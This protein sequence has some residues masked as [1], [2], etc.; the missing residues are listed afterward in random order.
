M[1]GMRQ[2]TP[3]LIRGRHKHRVLIDL[4]IRIALGGQAVE[5]DEMPGVDWR[6]HAARQDGRDVDSQRRA[7]HLGIS[8]S[9]ST[10][11]LMRM[12]GNRRRVRVLAGCGMRD[13]LGIA[14]HSLTKMTCPLCELRA[15]TA[16]SRRKSIEVR[17]AH[18]EACAC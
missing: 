1:E 14:G 7:R 17:R 10:S 18:S 2:M 8:S 13:M 5:A 9:A 6:A 12:S 16:S 15:V 11:A 4:R 3:H